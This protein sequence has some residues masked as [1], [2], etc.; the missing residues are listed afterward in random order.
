ML[1]LAGEVADEVMLGDLGSE[2][3]L[4]P[5]LA[6]V[7]TGAARTVGRSNACGGSPA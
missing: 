1:R 4:T 6:E 7:Q 5:A 2:A 3:V